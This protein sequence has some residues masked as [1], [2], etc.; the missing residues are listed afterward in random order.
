[1]LQ[2]GNVPQADH[3]ISAPDRRFG[4][5][6]HPLAHT[7]TETLASAEV[8]VLGAL[9]GDMP[10]AALL[11]RA[12]SETL[13]VAQESSR[14]AVVARLHSGDFDAVVFPVV[15]ARGLPTAPLIQQ[16][17]REHSRSTLFAIC[18]SPPLRA[19]ALLAAARAGARV[20][21]S[22]SVSELTA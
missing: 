19:N 9:L 16:C 12:A 7:M 22:P 4:R 15:D 18:C 21:V 3:D 8:R 13:H 14:F 17:V 6:A 10:E 11:A 5:F 20:V 2:Y 1:M